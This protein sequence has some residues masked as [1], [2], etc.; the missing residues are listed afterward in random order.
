[1]NTHLLQQHSGSQS[2]AALSCASSIP[3]TFTTNTTFKS[4]LPFTPRASSSASAFLSQN[5]GNLDRQVINDSV[6]RNGNRSDSFE[7]NLT[8][9]RDFRLALTG[10]HADADVELLDRNGR[11]VAVSNASGRASE[12]IHCTLE[13]DF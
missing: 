13:L 5:L 3:T 12:F 10:L 6:G 2:F 9:N 1:M 4:S 11:I 8:E 7:F